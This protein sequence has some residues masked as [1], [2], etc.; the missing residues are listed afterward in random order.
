MFQ[1][2][3]KSIVTRGKI[4]G[5]N[6]SRELVSGHI[7]V[8]PC[9]VHTDRR[10]LP[11]SHGYLRISVD[12][13]VEFVKIKCNKQ[14]WDDESVSEMSYKSKGAAAFRV[15]FEKGHRP[16]IKVALMKSCQ[17]EE[18]IVE[19]FCEQSST[20]NCCEETSFRE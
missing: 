13:N 3:L 7:T 6:H 4:T 16:S 9:R 11:K 14:K 17:S 5:N 2:A 10:T 19:I 18:P 20:G 1:S 8:K 15:F 12:H